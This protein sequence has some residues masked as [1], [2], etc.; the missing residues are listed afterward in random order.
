MKSL[1]DKKNKS[2]VEN[3]QRWTS[4]CM[5]SRPGKKQDKHTQL[6]SRNSALSVRIGESSEQIRL[7]SDILGVVPKEVSDG[8][9]DT[10]QTEVI[11]A[12]NSD[13]F[14]GAVLMSAAKRGH[15]ISM[16]R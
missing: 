4:A 15:T 10:V 3:I 12:T 16:R 2:R 9:V 5:S 11:E 7:H 1:Y 14:T 8:K 13:V 6:V